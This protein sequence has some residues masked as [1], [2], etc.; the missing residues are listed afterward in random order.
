M[1]CPAS[2]VSFHGRVQLG[3]IWQ[4]ADFCDISLKDSQSTSQTSYINIPGTQMTLV[5]LEKG[6]VLEGSTIKIEDKQVP[7][8]GIPKTIIIFSVVFFPVKTM[9]YILRGFNWQNP[10]DCYFYSLRLAGDLYILLY[11]TLLVILLDGFNRL[12]ANLET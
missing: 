2:H 9:F 3:P 7:G 1:D 4:Q 5:L 10:G 6:L 8:P 11:M 12:D